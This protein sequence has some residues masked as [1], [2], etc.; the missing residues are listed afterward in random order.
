[1]G[2]RRRRAL[3]WL[4]APLAVCLPCLLPFIVAAV[5]AGA[6]AGAAGSFVSDNALLLAVIAGFATVA[7][8]LIGLGVS[9]ASRRVRRSVRIFSRGG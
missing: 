8:L 7:V 1:M 6:G 9:R 4:A 3:L 5:L 2:S